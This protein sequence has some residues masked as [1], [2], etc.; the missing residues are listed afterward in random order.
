MLGHIEDKRRRLLS[1][2]KSLLNTLC[3]AFDPFEI[4]GRSCS[5]ALVDIREGLFRP[6]PYC[7]PSQKVRPWHKADMLNPLTNVSVGGKADMART[8]QYVR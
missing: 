5:C 1:L 7:A 3:A 8:C 6:D 2:E 4:C